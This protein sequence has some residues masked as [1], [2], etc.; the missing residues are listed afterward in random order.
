[1]RSRWVELAE[2]MR[3]AGRLPPDADPEALGATLMCL[4]PG[5]V[6]QRLLVGGVDARTLRAGF[7]ALTG[8]S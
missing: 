6:M 1:M 4:M 5:F 3:D 2:R 8:A 7:H